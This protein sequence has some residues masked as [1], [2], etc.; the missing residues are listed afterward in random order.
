MSCDKFISF[1]VTNWFLVFCKEQIYIVLTNRLNQTYL[2]CLFNH[3][4]ISKFCR[5]GF[6]QELA[7]FP[8]GSGSSSRVCLV[9]LLQYGDWKLV[10]A[11]WTTNCTPDPAHCTLYTLHFTLHN[12][13]CKLHIANCTLHTLQA[14]DY[15]L[16]TT[17]RTLHLELGK[18]KGLCHP[19]TVGLAWPCLETGMETVLKTL[20]TKLCAQNS[21]LY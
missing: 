16:Q 11:H 18:R 2:S 10:T 20:P 17:H 19:V 5:D 12:A 8:E 9:P 15:T 13:H 4:L 21:T 7:Q 1:V 3:I 6:Q 14:A